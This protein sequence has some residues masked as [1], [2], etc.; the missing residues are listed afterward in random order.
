MFIYEM[1]LGDESQYIYGEKELD[2]PQACNEAG[3]ELQNHALFGSMTEWVWFDHLIQLI[4][5]KNNYKWV[6]GDNGVNG[7]IR[8]A[9][10]RRI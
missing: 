6:N 5:K 3:V 8:V 4:C 7:T 10:P 1:K 2:L 9:M